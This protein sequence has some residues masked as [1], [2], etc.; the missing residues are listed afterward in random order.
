MNP[1]FLFSLE[2]QSK[3]SKHHIQ[4][5]VKYVN[6]VLVELPPPL[7]KDF[8][9]HVAVE[10]FHVSLICHKAR[11]YKSF[12]KLS[13]IILSVLKHTIIKRL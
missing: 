10:S 6:V 9:L 13:E 5:N 11:L 12:L 7:P 3:N 8:V 4:K 2:I 1:S